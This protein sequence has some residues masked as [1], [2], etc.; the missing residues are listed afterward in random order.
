MQWF[1]SPS[2]Y[3]EAARIIFEKHLDQNVRY[4]ET[5]FHAGM[6]EF[7]GL[8]G[9][10]ILEAILS[11]V[12]AGLE[13][14]VFMGM[15]RNSYNQ[16]LAPILEESVT[17]DGLSGLDLHGIEYLKLEKW[18]SRIWEKA[19]DRGLETKAH[20]GEF[21]PASHVEE[22]INVLG[23][24]RIQHGVRAVE[25]PKV[26]QLALDSNASFDLSISNVKL[27]VVESM[28]AHPIREFSIVAYVALSVL[29]ILFPLVIP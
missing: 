19:R 11:A 9:P 14:R 3:H 23:V 22:A 27:S 8:S 20:A 13:V 28:E 1:T 26:L 2:R 17:W 16:A 4:V 15:A 10:E 12:P 5:S 6:I 24:R 18:T 29:T 7:L 21:G 25:D